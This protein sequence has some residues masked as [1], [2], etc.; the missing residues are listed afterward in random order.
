MLAGKY[1]I[2]IEAGATFTL[3]LTYVGEDGAGVD[4]TGYSARMQMRTSVSS[5][6]VVLE[7]STTNGRISIDNDNSQIVLAIASADTEDL[8]GTGVY[9]L[10]LFNGSLVERLIEGSYTVIAEVTR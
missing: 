4:L 10:E 3:S 9:D 2:T 6:D 5:P 7:L 1:D 8:T